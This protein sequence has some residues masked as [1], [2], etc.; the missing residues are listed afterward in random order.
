MSRCNS[1]VGVVVVGAVVVLLGSSVLSE[2]QCV[3][4][5]DPSLNQYYWV[6]IV[7]QFYTLCYTRGLEDDANQVR[8]W[9]D[10]SYQL[11]RVKYGI[12]TPTNRERGTLRTTVF[13]PP[14][15]TSY[16]GR[17]RVVNFCCWG[18][19]EGYDS[20]MHYLSPA[21]WG[22]PPYGGLRYPSG[23][24][25]HAHYVMHEMVNLLHY[26]LEEQNR[27]TS[28][29]REG[30]AEYDGYF[31][32][33]E[34][35]RTVGIDRLFEYVNRRK[36]GDIH[37]CLTLSGELSIGSSDI[38]YGSAVIMVYLA[39]HFGEEI[40]VELFKDSLTD[41]LRSRLGMGPWQTFAHFSTWFYTQLSEME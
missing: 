17:G 36:R 26:S 30:L 15:P 41:I 38:Y 5:Q 20:E 23:E 16:T 2:A 33:T 35:N 4:S 40:H 6:P 25:Y 37:C 28:W 31:H 34:W 1:T 10:D 9:V 18:S 14:E 27:L 12:T 19:E 21:A 7:G 11:G 8:R 13:L 3:S 29:I 22:D 39:E 32:S 24:D